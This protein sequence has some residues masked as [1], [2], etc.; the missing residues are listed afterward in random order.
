MSA[1][2]DASYI[3]YLAGLDEIS[4]YRERKGAAE[5]LKIPPGVL[6]RQVKAARAAMHS[7]GNS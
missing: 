1:A 2:E 4:Y 5:N 3:A 7:R 6:D